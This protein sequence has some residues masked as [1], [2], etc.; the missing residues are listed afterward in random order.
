MR[1]L[2]QSLLPLVNEEQV[3]Y[4]KT[5]AKHISFDEKWE[6]SLS[7]SEFRAAAIQH[8]NSLPWK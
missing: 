8:T 4:V 5:S 7:A 2:N 3:A 6:E 1:V